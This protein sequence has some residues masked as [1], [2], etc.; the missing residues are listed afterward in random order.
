VTHVHQCR[1]RN[2]LVAVGDDGDGANTGTVKLWNLDEDDT[3]GNP[4]LVRTIKLFAASNQK[5]AVQPNVTSF[6]VADDLTVLVAGLSDGRVLLL[7]GDLVRDKVQ[8]TPRQVY[9]PGSEIS[10]VGLKRL[11]N[12]DNML[13]VT[14]LTEILSMRI[15]A[16]GD[17]AESEVLDGR[18][19]PKGL[20]CMSE[21]RDLV[22]AHKEAIYFFGA[23]GRGACFAFEGEKQLVSWFRSYLVLV[24]KDVSIYDL[25]NKLVAFSGPLPFV[26][27]LVNEWGGLYAVSDDKKMYL[28]AEKDVQTKLDTL[29]RKNLYQIAINLAQSQHLDDAYISDIFR[30]FGDHSYTKGDYDQAVSQYIKTIGR[31]EPSYVIRKF[32]D[33]QR[34]HN[35]TRYLEELHSKGVATAD[36]TTLL[37]NCYTK[38]KD[39]DKLDSFIKKNSSEMSYDVET[40]IRVCRQGGYHEH[41]LFLA[42]KHKEHEWC[43]RILVDDLKQYNDAIEYL[44]SLDFADAEQQMKLYATTLCAE[45]PAVAR[46]FLQ[47]LCTDHRPRK[48]PSAAPARTESNVSLSKEKDGKDNGKDKA[49]RDSLNQD[50]TSPQAGTK[51]EEKKKVVPLLTKLLD[52]LSRDTAEQQE[53]EKERERELQKERDRER[54]EREKEKEREREREQQ[55]SQAEQP[56]KKVVVQQ[57]DGSNVE[58]LSLSDL[59]TPT[60]PAAAATPS[61]STSSDRDRLFGGTR[62]SSDPIKASAASE[63]AKPTIQAAN[64][65]DFVHCFTSAPEELRVF[66]EFLISKQKASQRVFHTLLELYLKDQ[67]Y[68][69]ATRLLQQYEGMYDDRH[70]LLLV[71]TFHFTD[72]VLFLYEKMGL[73]HD[74]LHMHMENADPQAVVRTCEQYASG[75]ANMWS[76]VLAYFAQLSTTH[77]DTDYSPYI[78]RILSAIERENTLPPLS[79]LQLLS[80]SSSLSLG[81]VKGYLLNRLETEAKSIAEDEIAIKDYVEETTRMRTEVDELRTQAR[82]FQQSKCAGCGSSLDLPAVHFMCMHSFHLHC[83]GDNENECPICAP[84]AKRVIEIRRLQEESAGQHDAFFKMLDQSQDG[85]STVAEYFGR[86]IFRLK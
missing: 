68:T 7:K 41:A 20:V 38:L 5:Q 58:V 3:Q 27:F 78:R 17:V 46:E 50:T 33:A 53:R 74:I 75:D 60:T 82:I 36:H 25:R 43:M 22:V 45:V 48:R 13:F 31:L 24:G 14:S 71:Q 79:V 62:T 10:F 84:R 28:L 47:S 54:A 21:D 83:M 30:K 80:R 66:L 1:S 26:R 52:K 15:G 81:A 23:E 57:Q 37:I 69:E 76:Q 35:L 55:H 2:I 6:D 56:K 9:G 12:A 32:L 11:S 59:I 8:K 18:G 72:G 19:V 34:I 73:Y 39:V 49:A 86:G 63:P 65:E 29:F 44:Y 77:P 40:A 16:K 61:S 85:F 70:A 67:L 42:L 64:A 4:Y 51:K